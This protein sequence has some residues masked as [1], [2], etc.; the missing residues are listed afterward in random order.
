MKHYFVSYASSRGFG[1]T[2]I[3]VPEGAT[4]YIKGIEVELAREA[5]EPWICVLYFTETTREICEG[6]V[7]RGEFK[8]IWTAEP[9]VEAQL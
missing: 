9:P 1:R 3:T 2:G 8:A 4:L 7:D 6:L 5:G